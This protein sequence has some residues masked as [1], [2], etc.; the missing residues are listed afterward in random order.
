MSKPTGVLLTVGLATG[1]TAT[2]DFLDDG[3]VK[4]RTMLGGLLVAIGL[5]WLDDADHALAIAFATLLLVSSAIRNVDSITAIGN[6]VRNAGSTG[7]PEAP[8]LDGRRP[9]T[10]GIGE[11]F[12]P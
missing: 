4:L 1:L 6:A 7:K 8:P 11:G 12:A 9:K 10:K 5:T 2:S 3:S